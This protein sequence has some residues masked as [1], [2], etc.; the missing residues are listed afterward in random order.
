MKLVFKVI[1][2][3]GGMVCGG[4][5]VDT[6]LHTHTFYQA[7]DGGTINTKCSV[8]GFKNRSYHD[9]PIDRVVRYKGLRLE[10]MM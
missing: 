2:G 4:L 7:G 8:I 6:L 9:T 10:R 5:I 3:S 1:A